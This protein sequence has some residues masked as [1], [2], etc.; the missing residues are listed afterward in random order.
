MLF[1]KRG[2]LSRNC[3][4]LPVPVTLLRMEINYRSFLI[5][6]GT[7]SLLG[8]L[9]T[10]LLEFLPVSSASHAGNS[11][12]L[13][14]DSLY[15]A[16]LWILFL[17]PQFNFIAALGIAVV[18]FRKSPALVLTGG[19]FL[20][21][22]AIAEML[23]QALLIDALNQFWRPAYLG[24]ADAMS[25]DIYLT[26]IKGTDALSDSQY[27]VVLYAFGLGTFFYGLALIRETGRIKWLGLAILFIGVLSLCAFLR[28]YLGI[29]WLASPVDWLYKWIHGYLQILV[30]VAMAL[31]L[32]SL[33][34]KLTRPAP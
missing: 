13:H 3:Y 16:R 4:R 32:F 23:Q 20:L 17:H 10:G 29:D 22:W 21:V 12:L 26:L 1:A 9:T 24:A 5:L 18:L 28:Y 11:L 33:A 6:A 15:L 19:F 2:M 27:F 31:Y 14:K 30:R 34:G 8:A 7:C 25:R